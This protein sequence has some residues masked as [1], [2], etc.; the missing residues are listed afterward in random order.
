MERLLEHE[1]KLPLL[2]IKPPIEEFLE[3]LAVSS[4]KELNPRR[5]GSTLNGRR[6]DATVTCCA[7]AWGAKKS[8]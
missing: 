3:H 6:S 7:K 4:A 5:K 1:E 2:Q 8:T